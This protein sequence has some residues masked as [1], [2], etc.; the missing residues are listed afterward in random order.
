MGC[1]TNGD[2]S[3]NWKV[4]ERKRTRSGLTAVY[5]KHLSLA[6]AAPTSPVR[7]RHFPNSFSHMGEITPVGVLTCCG[8]T[9][10]SENPTR[11]LRFIISEN[12]PV[13]SGAAQWIK[14]VNTSGE[15]NTLLLDLVDGPRL[16]QHVLLIQPWVKWKRGVCVLPPLLN[17]LNSVLT[18]LRCKYA[19]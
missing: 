4:G 1:G 18:W 14:I 12:I 3:G 16:E 11:S 6:G 17:L 9:R 19:S 5:W 8:S 7:I 10:E 15:K 13:S 2:A